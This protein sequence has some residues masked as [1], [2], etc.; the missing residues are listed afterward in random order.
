[1][2]FEGLVALALLQGAGFLCLYHGQETRNFRRLKDSVM[3]DKCNGLNLK[4]VL[5]SVGPALADNGNL[6]LRLNR[7]T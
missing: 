4:E 3:R 2:L 5:D 6:R 1:M 7:V